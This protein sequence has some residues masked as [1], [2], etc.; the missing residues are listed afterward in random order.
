MKLS[1]YEFDEARD[2]THVDEVIAAARRA[3]GSSSDASIDAF[4]GGDPLPGHLLMGEGTWQ[5]LRDAMAYRWTRSFIAV[6]WPG[7][8]EAATAAAW[9]DFHA[10]H[11]YGSRDRPGCPPPPSREHDGRWIGLPWDKVR[12]HLAGHVQGDQLAL[13]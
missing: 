6:Y 12:E 7:E 2:A 11:G 5:Q 9:H 1:G 4:I 13:T 3:F 8:H 10:E